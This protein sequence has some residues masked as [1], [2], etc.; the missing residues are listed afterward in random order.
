MLS[1]VTSLIF[2]TPKKSLRRPHSPVQ[3][4]VISRRR[5]SIGEKEVNSDFNYHP[6]N[7]SIQEAKKETQVS[8]VEYVQISP[9]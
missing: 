3:S 4:P 6:S 1:G 9:V 2:S 7:L 5:S 8:I